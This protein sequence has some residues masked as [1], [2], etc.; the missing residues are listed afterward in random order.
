MDLNRENFFLSKLAYSALGKVERFISSSFSH[1]QAYLKF[2][3][4][5]SIYDFGT[6]DS[7]AYFLN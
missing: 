1:H 4:K 6:S 5:S 7:N 2:F 3:M